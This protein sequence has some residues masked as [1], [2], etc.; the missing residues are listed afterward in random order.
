MVRAA[1]LQKRAASVGFDWPDL[2][3]V[4]AKLHEETGELLSEWDA[5]SRDQDKLQDEMGDVLFVASNL[6]RKVG[7]DPE[8]ALLAA[9]GNS[10]HAFATLRHHCRHKAVILL[11]QAWMRWNNYGKR[12]NL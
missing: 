12:P 2:R 1:K 11:R 5:P 8:T 10:K 4:I 6:A 7:V 9:I 3:A